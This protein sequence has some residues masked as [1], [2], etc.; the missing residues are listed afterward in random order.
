MKK[1]NKGADGSADQLAWTHSEPQ[2]AKLGSAVDFDRCRGGLVHAAK[3]RSWWQWRSWSAHDYTGPRPEHGL[4]RQ[5]SKGR[6]RRVEGEELVVM[7][8]EDAK[9]SRRARCRCTGKDGKKKGKGI[10]VESMTDNPV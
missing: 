7:G 5:R 1:G 10:P 3:G 6:P 9:R 8:A 4:A 2:R